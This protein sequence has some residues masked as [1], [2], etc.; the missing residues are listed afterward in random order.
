MNAASRQTRSDRDRALR[1]L[2]RLTIGAAVAGSI[3]TAAFSG[4]ALVTYRGATTD[5]TGVDVTSSAGTT[6]GTTDTSSTTSSST[7][8]SSTTNGLQ[9]TTTTPT[10]TSGG[11]HVSTGGSG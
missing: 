9:S 8:S 5:S 2:S 10:T 11:G 7:T 1:R 4:L 6:S 3:G